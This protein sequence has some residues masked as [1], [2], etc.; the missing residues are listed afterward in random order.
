MTQ[1]ETAPYY[2]RENGKNGQKTPAEPGAAAASIFLAS[3]AVAGVVRLANS[4]KTAPHG[5]VGRIEWL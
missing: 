2:C 3:I 4:H 1:I 5:I